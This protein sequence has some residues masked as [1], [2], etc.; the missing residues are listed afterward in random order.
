MVTTTHR[1]AFLT[2]FED[3]CTEAFNWRITQ[4]VSPEKKVPGNVDW[5]NSENVHKIEV[6][7]GSVSV[8]HELALYG[9]N[10][11]SL[12][13]QRRLMRLLHFTLKVRFD[14]WNSRGMFCSGSFRMASGSQTR[15]QVGAAW[16][17][18]CGRP[19][20]TMRRGRNRAP[21]RAPGSTRH[22]Q[23]RLLWSGKEPSG[24][25][26]SPTGNKPK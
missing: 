11:Y 9:C 19:P 20:W 4:W 10:L 6:A 21:W 23:A 12:T 18:I 22:S 13:W 16:S 3:N 2:N 14:W 24:I 25:K 5:K 1:E 8:Q 17:Q 7:P 15:K 26:T